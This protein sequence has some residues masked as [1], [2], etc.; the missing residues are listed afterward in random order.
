MEKIIEVEGYK[1]FSGIMKISPKANV[2][3]SFELFGDWLYK[4]DTKCWYGCGF[5]F[6][7]KICEILEV[8]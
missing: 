2:L 3:P 4:P 1:A 7:E 5:S 6:P 8:K